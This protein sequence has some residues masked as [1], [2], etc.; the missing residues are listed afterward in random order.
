MKDGLID[1][2]ARALGELIRKGEIKPAELLET[3]IQR[4]ERINPEINSVVSSGRI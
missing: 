4:I 2:D 1:Y 3:V